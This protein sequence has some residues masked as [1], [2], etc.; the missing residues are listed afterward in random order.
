MKKKKNNQEFR[1]FEIIRINHAQM[2]L[3]N[4][5]DIIVYK[6]FYLFVFVFTSQTICYETCVIHNSFFFKD[7]HNGSWCGILN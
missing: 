3:F 7:F 4:E 1:Y 2:Y 5:N 6:I